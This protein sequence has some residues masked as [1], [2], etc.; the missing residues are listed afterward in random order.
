VGG[1]S[2]A[3]E[4]TMVELTEEE[5]H[6]ICAGM[7]TIGQLYDNLVDENKQEVKPDFLELKL[8][9]QQFIAFF[10]TIMVAHD[11]IMHGEAYEEQALEQCMLEDVVAMMGQAMQKRYPQEVKDLLAENEAAGGITLETNPSAG[12][13]LH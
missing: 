9:S 2:T 4:N 10:R 11:T 13:V 1:L 5:K 3:K 8:D 7:N 6:A 12:K